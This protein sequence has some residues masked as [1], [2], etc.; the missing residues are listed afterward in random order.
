MTNY[1]T[2]IKEGK[3]QN[4]RLKWKTQQKEMVLLELWLDIY[5]SPPIFKIISF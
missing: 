2:F 5:F 1:S 3:I 4:G